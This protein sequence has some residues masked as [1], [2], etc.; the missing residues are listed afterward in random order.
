MDK[1]YTRSD[2]TFLRECVD[3][4][5][6]DPDFQDRLCQRIKQ[7]LAK[8]D[9]QFLSHTKHLLINM[10]RKEKELETAQFE[11]VSFL[12]ATHPG[13]FLKRGAR[14]FEEASSGNSKSRKEPSRT[15]ALAMTSR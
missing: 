7:H 8:G 11:F 15:D 2:A 9:P 14:E 6:R 3:Q 13:I 10:L 4:M 1:K 5:K 12:M